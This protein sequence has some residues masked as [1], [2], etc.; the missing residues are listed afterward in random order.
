MGE[1]GDITKIKPGEFVVL[2]TKGS[3]LSSAPKVPTADKHCP[4]Q[5][6][7]HV[8]QATVREEGGFPEHSKEP[9]PGREG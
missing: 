5:M 3:C 1:L 4:T 9:G 2:L 6:G 8:A 7:C